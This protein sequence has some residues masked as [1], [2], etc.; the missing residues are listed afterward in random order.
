V[1]FSKKRTQVLSVQCL[2]KGD[3][4]LGSSKVVGQTINSEQ[5]TRVQWCLVEANS[6]NSI[7]SS[8]VSNMGKVNVME[9]G[10]IKLI[11]LLLKKGIARR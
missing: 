9:G 6:S 4:T 10:L 11:R 8:R 7:L 5:G 2:C 1:I 3:S